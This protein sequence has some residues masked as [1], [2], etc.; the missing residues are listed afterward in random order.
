MGRMGGP[1]LKVEDYSARLRTTV[2]ALP[3]GLPHA[4]PLAAR[5]RRGSV[6]GLS[7]LA[8]AECVDCVGGF[9]AQGF[10]SG[11]DFGREAGEPVKAI[12]CV[13]CGDNQTVEFR[14]IIR[15][16]DHRTSPEPAKLPVGEAMRAGDR[17]ALAANEVGTE[18]RGFA[19]LTLSTLNRGHT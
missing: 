7:S 6:P 11:D 13:A 1:S 5:R 19:F 14:V 8:V 2:G 17:M 9:V 3:D 16:H 10:G 15:C 18:R 12:Q 4:G